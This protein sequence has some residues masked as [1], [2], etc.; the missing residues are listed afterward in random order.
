MCLFLPTYYLILNESLLYRL[1]NRKNRVPYAEIQ[2]E[3]WLKLIFSGWGLDV[4]GALMVADARDQQKFQH[5][6]ASQ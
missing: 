6:G 4:D 1:Y 3:P 2:L 5:T